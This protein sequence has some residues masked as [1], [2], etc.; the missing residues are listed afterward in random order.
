LDFPLLLCWLD[1]GRIDG[2]MGLSLPWDGNAL[3]SAE[4]TWESDVFTYHDIK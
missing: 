2:E 4:I 3:V 1:S